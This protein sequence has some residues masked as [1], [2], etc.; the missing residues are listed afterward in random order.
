MRDAQPALFVV[1]FSAHVSPA[2]VN[3]AQLIGVD[4]VSKIDA[5]E[6]LRALAGR[7]DRG[8]RRS[9]E[10][11]WLGARLAQQHGLSEGEARV[12]QL[13]IFAYRIREIAEQLGLSPNTVK[14]VLERVRAKSGLGR[15]ALIR[16]GRGDPS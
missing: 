3:Y 11:A 12:V 6:N 9:D 4:F 7:I 14:R 5:G 16:L 15:D 2:I 1:I 8:S 10:I 13:A